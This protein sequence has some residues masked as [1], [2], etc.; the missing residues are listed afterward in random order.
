MGPANDTRERLHRAILDMR[1][2][3]LIRFARRYRFFCDPTT[4]RA[5][6]AKSTDEDVWNTIVEHNAGWIGAGRR[7]WFWLRHWRA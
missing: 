5:S 4:V 1:A 6:L 7:V 2:A 3:V